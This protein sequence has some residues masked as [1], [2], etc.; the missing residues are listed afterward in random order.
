MTLDERRSALI[1]ATLPLLLTRGTDLSTREIARAAGVAEGTIFRA[2]ETKQDLLH[3]TIGTAL[4]PDEALARIAALP[5]EQA[6]VDRVAALLDV[7]RAEI[8]RTRSLFAH[9]AHPPVP[10]HSGRAA[11][12]WPPI[13]PHEARARLVEAVTAALQPYAGELTVP[14]SFAAQMLSSLA[15]ATSFALPED[16]PLRQS[17][18]L[19]AVVLHGIA[20][21]E[22]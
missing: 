7:L 3:A 1:E 2:F 17:S 15:F 12:G 20:R 6:I 5:P 19:A 10:Q 18:N 22:S 16:H 11:H 8:V 9:F 14:A 4:Q 13:N 21:G